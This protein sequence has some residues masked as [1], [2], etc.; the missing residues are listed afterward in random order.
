MDEQ[1]RL[2]VLRQRFCDA[3]STAA[4]SAG[5]GSSSSAAGNTRRQAATISSSTIAPDPRPSRD[6]ANLT[7]QPA[8]NADV[9]GGSGGA[10]VATV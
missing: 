9:S 3:A 5:P 8:R 4:P 2:E 1:D 10:P 7:Q 6:R